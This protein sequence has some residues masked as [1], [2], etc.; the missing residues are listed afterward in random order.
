MPQ[1]TRSIQTP[2]RDCEQTLRQGSQTLKDPLRFDYAPAHAYLNSSALDKYVVVVLL[3]PP[4]ISTDP[5]GK[6]VAV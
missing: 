1:S 3:D 2:E 5:L 4:A 6:S